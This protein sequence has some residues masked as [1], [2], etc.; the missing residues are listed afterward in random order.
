MAKRTTAQ[1][2]RL[3]RKKAKEFKAATRCEGAPRKA[4]NLN[5]L[6]MI[7]RNGSGCH[8]DGKKAASKKACRVKVRC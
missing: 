7:L 4:R 2:K 8:G 3:A 5:V 6:G 1:R